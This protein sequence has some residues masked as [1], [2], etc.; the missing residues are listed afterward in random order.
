MTIGGWIVMTFWTFVKKNNHHDQ[1]TL[2][3]LNLIMHTIQPF[4]IVSHCIYNTVQVHVICNLITSNAYYA[5][6]VIRF[7]DEHWTAEARQWLIKL[8]E[9]MKVTDL[10]V[11]T[12]VTLFT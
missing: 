3:T 5:L 8:N 12:L 1:Q 9:L 2:S 6:L 10:S 4:F 7:V 11:L